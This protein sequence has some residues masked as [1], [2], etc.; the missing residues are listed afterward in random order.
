MK[1]QIDTSIKAH[2]L[3]SALYVILLLAVCVIPFALGQ[4]SIIGRNSVK[5]GPSAHPRF[6]HSPL[7]PATSVPNGTCI[8]VNGDFETGDLTGWT[9]TG[10]TSFTGVDS[11]EVHSGVFAL[12]AGPT[13]SDGFVDQM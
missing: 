1:K 7:A 11:S 6:G 3:R 9:N 10:D 13:T 4:R 12:F 8:V 2:L 5:S